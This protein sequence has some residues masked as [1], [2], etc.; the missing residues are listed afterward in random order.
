MS[1]RHAV[2]KKLATAYK[3]GARPDKSKILD[4]LVGLTGWLGGW[5]RTRSCAAGLAAEGRR[6]R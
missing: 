3:R 6:T 1:T 5:C 2:T 4:E